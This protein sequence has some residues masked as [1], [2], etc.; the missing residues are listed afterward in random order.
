MEKRRDEGQTRGRT[1]Q[2]KVTIFSSANTGLETWGFL[3][4]VCLRKAFERAIYLTAL[5]VN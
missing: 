3:L 5:C 2:A 1:H 4:D